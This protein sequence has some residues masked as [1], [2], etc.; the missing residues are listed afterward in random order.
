MVSATAPAS[1]LASARL[2]AQ[3]PHRDPSSKVRMED[4]SQNQTKYSYDYRPV[5]LPK[6]D[7]AFSSVK[8]PVLTAPVPRQDS[9]NTKYIAERVQATLPLVTNNL[10]TK[11]HSLFDPV[12]ELVLDPPRSPPHTCRCLP[13]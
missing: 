3:L 5:F 7:A 1:V 13:A 6:D 4:I 12:D 2:R 8:F 9:F 11:A 10:L